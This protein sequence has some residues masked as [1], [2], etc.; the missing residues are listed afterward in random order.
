MVKKPWDGRKVRD[1][2]MFGTGILGV[3]YETVVVHVDR[4]ALLALFA[5]MLGLPL[6]LRRDESHQA[7]ALPEKEQTVEK[8]MDDEGG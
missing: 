2:I 6:F 7:K 3:V 1:W 8:P 4:P 5:S